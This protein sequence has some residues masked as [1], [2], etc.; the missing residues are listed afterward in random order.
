MNLGNIKF[1]AKA[2]LRVLM[3]LIFLSAAL[4]R[5]FNPEMA[6]FELSALSLPSF[7]LWPLVIFEFLTGLF[8]LINFRV[9]STALVLIVFLLF[10]LIQALLVN[11]PEIWREASQLFIFQAN[12]V[13]WFLHL[14]FVF[15]LVNLVLEKREK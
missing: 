4:F 12:P 2:I 7:L 1:S 5:I 6:R 8:L 3:G 15:I 9:R 10:A 14:V 11:G 13:E